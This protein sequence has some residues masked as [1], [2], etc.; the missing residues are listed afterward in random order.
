[1]TR[2]C[3]RRSPLGCAQTLWRPV[4]ARLTSPWRSARSTITP[5]VNDLER[6][7]R[8]RRAAL[9]RHTPVAVAIDY[10]LKN[11]TA[12]TRFLADGRI[13]L[14]NNAAERARRG[15]AIGMKSWLFVGS[16]RGGQRTALMYSLIVTAKLIVDR[17]VDENELLE[18]LHPPKSQHGTVASSKR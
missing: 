5:L 2:C 17:G 3:A 12:F 11:W 9:A 13:C 18:R 15:I 8:E 16:D 7:R 4:A 6:W 14:T 1:M 10:M